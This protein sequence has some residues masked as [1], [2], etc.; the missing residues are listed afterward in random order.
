MAGEMAGNTF[1]PPDGAA[2]KRRRHPR[3]RL[4]AVE[5]PRKKAGL[6]ADGNGLYLVVDPSG[7]RR[8]MLRTTVR[9][10][11][12]AKRVEIGLGSTRLVSLAD[13]RTEAARLRRI[14]RAG[15]DPLATRRRARVAVPTFA[16][17]ARTVHRDHSKTFRNARHRETWLAS[18]KADV[19][20][21]FGDRRVDLVDSA[22]VLKAL[23]PLWTTKPETARRLKQR[24]RV[25]LDWA[26]AA[27]HRQGDNPVD[28][29]KRAL[30]NAR[31][32]VRHLPALPYAQLPAFMKALRELSG[33]PSVRLAFEFLILT[34]ARTSEV[35]GARWNEIDRE[36]RIWTVPA[37]RIKAG[38]EHRVAL[39]DRA[40]EILAAAEA[41][42]ADDHPFVFPGRGANRPLSSMA[43]LMAI[44]RLDYG[45][46]AHG[47]RSSFRDWAAERTSF[48][49]AVC[50][51]ALA[52]VIPNAVEAAYLRSDLLEMRR[53]LMETWA[54]FAT[55]MPADVVQLRA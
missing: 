41:M 42:R 15:G 19:F 17:A 6:H 36:V 4:T 11:G 9:T 16:E 49:R 43:F 38:R 22:D 14:A 46:T 21:V 33:A 45:I 2:R 55:S 52:H 35:I 5:V 54:T 10:D 13:A 8:W 12:R 20:P 44:R 37:A 3:E 26:K 23:T 32:I 47:F 50:E 39:S 34:A 53:S 31:R 51:A 30:P 27:G 24:I 28:S 40:L 48:P 18:L 25:V 1:A 29:V 7:A